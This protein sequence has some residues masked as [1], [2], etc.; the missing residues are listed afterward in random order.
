M[1]AR[2]RTSL[3]ALLIVTLLVTG[4]QVTPGSGGSPAGGVGTAP[5]TGEL[6]P[7]TIAMGFMPNIQFAPMYVA[8]HNGYFAEEG[9]DITL[10]YGME[11]DLLERLAA[12]EIRFAI[13]SGDQ[14]VLARAQ[15]LPV[16]YVLNW[17]R[18]FPVCV[19]ALADSGIESIDDLVG[20]TVGI[21]V[22]FG[23]SYIG[24]MGFVKAVGLNPQAVNL[25]TIGYTQV[26]SLLE[27]RVDAAIV[28]A[29]NEP[30]QLRAAGHEINVFYL[31][32]Y[33]ALVSNGIIT[34]D[35]T[36]E[37]EP[38]LVRSVVRAFLRGLEDTLADP[39]AAF[40]IARN[41]IPEMDDETAALQRA[42]LD[43]SIEFWRSERA[44]ATDPR[45][46]EASVALL[47]EMG[48]LTTDVDPESLYSNAFLPEGE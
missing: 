21:P 43:E 35:V 39:D 10:D 31:D 28:Y 29:Q 8:I 22:T 42:V 32:E 38:E 45:A 48:L 47:T 44:G 34:N 26:A 18:R 46:W 25:Q 19:V 27:G 41:A 13:G 16:Q 24:W 2:M 17:Y 6:R 1:E 30:V 7:L 37:E 11:T 3:A 23:A 9:L 5:A 20:K 15:G 4:C 12:E 14:V 33:T 36:A 40:E